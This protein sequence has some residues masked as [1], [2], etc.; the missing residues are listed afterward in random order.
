MMNNIIKIFSKL[1]L[2]SVI[3]ISVVLYSQEATTENS[4]QQASSEDKEQVF[5]YS[6]FFNNISNNDYLPLIGFVNFSGEKTSLGIGFINAHDDTFFTTGLI[7]ISGKSKL[8]FGLINRSKD[9]FLNG[10]LIN[11]AKKSVFQIGLVNVADESSF[12]GIGLLNFFKKDG[13]MA[14]DYSFDN[15]YLANLTF[16]TGLKFFY[17]SIIV[18]YGN[19]PLTSSKID[20]VDDKVFTG[21]GVGSILDLTDLIYVN[22]ELQYHNIV[23]EKDTVLGKVNLGVNVLSFV[24]LF[25]GLN[26]YY[27]LEP[28]NKFEVGFN[29]GF[30]TTLQLFQ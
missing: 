10:G 23:N 6:F 29:V 11:I 28:D 3:F 9:T 4:S 12:G 1:F 7:N 27:D 25:G 5:F 22:P 13:Y 30:R 16:S 20:V 19:S 8:S 17:S 21:L 15:R 26:V 18:S 2:L 24:S 14:L